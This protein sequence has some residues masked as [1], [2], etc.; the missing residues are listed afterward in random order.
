MSILY[1]FFSVAGHITQLKETIAIKEYSCHEWIYLW[2][3][4]IMLS[5]Q[6]I[7]QSMTMPPHAFLLQCILVLFLP[8][9]QKMTH[10]LSMLT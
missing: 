2:L 9:V 1:I 10:M 3:Y 4:L 7:A 6:N 5:Q 8:Q